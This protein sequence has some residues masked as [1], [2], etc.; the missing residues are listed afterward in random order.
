MQ[1]ET[2]FIQ[3]TSTEKPRPTNLGRF[4]ERNKAMII[5]ENN[6]RREIL[7]EIPEI[8]DWEEFIWLFQNYTPA[9]VEIRRLTENRP[10]V[11][12]LREQ[13]IEN[14]DKALARDSNRGSDFNKFTSQIPTKNQI[15]QAFLDEL[16]DT[17]F[18]EDGDSMIIRL[19]E[20]AVGLTPTDYLTKN[21]EK[22]P[23]GHEFHNLEIIFREFLEGVEGFRKENEAKKK[24]NIAQG[25][26]AFYQSQ[27]GNS[28]N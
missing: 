3:Q 1:S 9:I 15:L 18:V 25:Y 28:K 21:I 27:I 14:G 5:E 4:L 13:S 10:E 7:R 26:R 23:E 11:V 17:E 22:F 20:G 16:R 8:Q 19:K 24:E 6:S 12:E 2:Q